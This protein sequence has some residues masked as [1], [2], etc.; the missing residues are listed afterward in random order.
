MFMWTRHSLG[1]GWQCGQKVSELQRGSSSFGP[2]HAGPWMPAQ[3]AVRAL[4]VC[5]E[6]TR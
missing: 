5:V 2:T 1:P 6:V 3:D 4:G